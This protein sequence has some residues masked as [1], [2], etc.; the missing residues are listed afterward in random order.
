MIPT[1]LCLVLRSH[2]AVFTHSPGLCYSS[3]SRDSEAEKVDE[4]LRLGD[5][6]VLPWRSAQLNKQTGWW[7]NQDRRDKETIV[8][9]GS[10]SPPSLSPLFSPSLPPPPSLSPPSNPLLPLTPFLFPPF[11]LPTATSCPSLP[12]PVRG[13]VSLTGTQYGDTATYTCDTG[14]VL[15][16]SA[17]RT[18]QSNGRWSGEIPTC[19]CK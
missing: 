16:G 8:R 18:C 7:D 10:S 17:V 14:Y 2:S 1:P 12:D 11:S 6:P 5:Y 3:S 15:S 4:G 9:E 19:I 13:S